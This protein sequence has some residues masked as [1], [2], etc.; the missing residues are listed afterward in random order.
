MDTI[1]LVDGMNLLFQMFFGMPAR[2]VN[3]DGK[4]IQGTLGFVGAL[5]K[6][7]RMVSPSYCA[8]LFDGEHENPRAELL[9]D[10]KANR[11]DYADAPEEESPFSQLADVYRALDFLRIKHTEIAAV[12]ADDVL[13]GYALA[14]GAAN[15]VVIASFDSDF[16]QLVN[17]NVSILRYR[18]ANTALCDEAY[19]RAR[20]G[21]SP[22]QY[23]GH[24]A[25]TGDTA[26][27]IK[28]IRGVGPKTAATLMN[29]FG[30]LENLLENTAA[31]AKPSIREAIERDAA[32]LRINH[33][34]IALGGGASL[35][36]ALE[37]LAYT[38]GGTATN[39]VLAGIGLK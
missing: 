33:A 15:R 23:A 39:E 3:K 19:V 35:P 28:G 25:L 29:Q 26:D 22:A 32:R 20:F 38:Y 13:A 24:K 16:F 34:L 27:N 17:G 1:L 12:E 14:H 21:I 7:I 11:V 30:S 36:F 8:V 5:L 6:I 2:I 37:E 10:Y 31:I 9:P 4:A 18:G